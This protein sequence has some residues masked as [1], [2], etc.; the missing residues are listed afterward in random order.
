ML[1]LWLPVESRLLHIRSG[2]WRRYHTGHAWTSSDHERHV[3]WKTEMPR[4]LKLIIT[5]WRAHE[6]YS[7]WKEAAVPVVQRLSQH[8]PAAAYPPAPIKNYLKHGYSREDS[9][10]WLD[11][12]WAL[13]PGKAWQ[14]PWCCASRPTPGWRLGAGDR[15]KSRGRLQS[16]LTSQSPRTRQWGF[17]QSQCSSSHKHTALHPNRQQ[18]NKALNMFGIS[19]YRKSFFYSA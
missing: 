15:S 13:E 6:T 1:V 10:P 5:S 2:T 12:L 16:S 3:S 9:V 18:N 19:R 14:S 4:D 8:Q 17:R 11:I 7:S